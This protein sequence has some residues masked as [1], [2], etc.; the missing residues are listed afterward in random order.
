[1]PSTASS[2]EIEYDGRNHASRRDLLPGC[3]GVKVPQVLE[4]QDA[5]GMAVAPLRLDGIAADILP[6]AQFKAG[7]RE[8]LRRRLVLD[9]DVGLALAHRARTGAPQRLEVKITLM[10][11]LPHDGEDVVHGFNVL[12]FHFALV[13]P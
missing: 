11:I 6:T 4:R 1:M 3:V 8:L 13:F 7:G 9:H 12:R 2:S 10:P 5:R